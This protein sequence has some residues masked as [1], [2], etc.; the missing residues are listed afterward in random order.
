VESHIADTVVAGAFLC[1][2][3]AV[4]V[5]ARDQRA[6]VWALVCARAHTPHARSPSRRRALAFPRA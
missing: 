4:E 1:K 6:R 2:L 5:R 3:P